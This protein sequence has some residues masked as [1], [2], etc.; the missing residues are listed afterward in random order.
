M[1]TEYTWHDFKD[2]HPF[3]DILTE[4]C[5][6][7]YS[8]WKDGTINRYFIE[9]DERKLRDN[10]P[11]IMRRIKS[12]LLYRRADN[13]L[14]TRIDEIRV[15]ISGYGGCAS[16]YF[17]DRNFILQGALSK[18]GSF[19]WDIKNKFSA[20]VEDYSK[21]IAS[22]QRPLVRL[23]EHN[24]WEC[25][26]W[27]FYCDYPKDVEHIE[28]LNKLKHRLEVMEPIDQT[29]GKSSYRVILAPTEFE[30]V[31]WDSGKRGYMRAFNY[32]GETLDIDAINRIVTLDDQGVFEELYKGGYKNLCA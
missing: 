17:D 28:A 7:S 31:R 24:G 1:K 13:E 15:D 9:F 30:S 20:T 19:E 6:W 8:Y 11:E 25:E 2:S 22:M 12:K 23:F 21:E 18:C 4:L 5:N 26:S 29:I 10:W 16:S 14:R 32:I 3:R 27:N